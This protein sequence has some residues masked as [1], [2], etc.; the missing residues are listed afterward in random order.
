MTMNGA[1]VCEL[2]MFAQFV[3]GGMMLILLFVHPVI[4]IL[5]ICVAATI[6]A[7]AVA[8]WRLVVAPWLETNNDE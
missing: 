7:T 6:G 3:M 5:M 1:E 8:L 4:G 2:R